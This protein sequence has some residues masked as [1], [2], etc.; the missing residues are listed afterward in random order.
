[1]PPSPA[2][3]DTTEPGS[4]AGTR[5][6]PP[7]RWGDREQ[8][9]IDILDAA[10]ELIAD[11][12]YLSLNMRDLAAAAGI[13]PATLYSYFAT[14]EE[15]F[16]TLYAE[17]IRR[18]TAQLR[19][20]L[21]RDQPLATLLE[22]VLIR[23]LDL[24]RAYGRYFTLWSALRE[25]VDPSRGPF[26]RELIVELRDATIEYSRLVIRSVRR[27]A[28]CDGRRFVD[29]EM[30]PALLWSSLNGIAD[31]LTSERRELDPFDSEKLVPFAA[32]RLA[33]ALTDPA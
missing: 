14:K 20:G 26:P 30:G 15:L 4:S 3:A 1:M 32:E 21:E 18:H 25:D 7:T 29:S 9:R 22:L 23:Y 16:V 10:R 8:R 27:A 33:G 6:R 17:A 5:D 31:H 13:S 2:D 11:G 19:P 24:Y 28:A 12:G